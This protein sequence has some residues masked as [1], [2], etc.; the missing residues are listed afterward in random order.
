MTRVYS[1][2]LP[3]TLLGFAIEDIYLPLHIKPLT[4]LM[5]AIHLVFMLV[6]VFSP[7]PLGT[8]FAYLL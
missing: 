3:L 8:N 1:P 2:F 5:L 6:D 4:D 7:K